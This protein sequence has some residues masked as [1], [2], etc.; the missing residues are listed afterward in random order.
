MSDR[1]LRNVSLAPKNYEKVKEVAKEHGFGGK[2]FSAALNYIISVYD[3]IT[4][5]TPPEN[6]K[7]GEEA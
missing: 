4:A 3:E 1:V 5:P 2:G 7:E 6:G